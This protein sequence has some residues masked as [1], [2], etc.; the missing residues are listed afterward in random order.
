VLTLRALVRL[1]RL[2]SSLLCALP[3]FV[4]FMGRTKSFTLSLGNAMPLLFIGM[5][6]FIAND[7]EDLEKDRLIHPERPLPAR[8]L[9][10]EF[11]AILYFISLG[12]ALFSTRY[13]VAQD[14]AFWYYGLAVLS[15]SYVY[16]VDGLPSLKTVYV[17]VASSIPVLIIARWFPEEPRLYVIAVAVFLFT[18]GREIC[19]DIQD[20]AG[21]A[22]CYIHRFKPSSLAVVAFSLSAVGIVLLAFEV[23]RPGEIADLVAMTLILAMAA[24]YWFK[25]GQHRRATLLMKVQLFVG[26][27][28]LV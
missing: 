2:S 7:L 12:V 23:R 18:L 22:P 21:D 14:I 1:T 13:F 25:F 15:I 10:P 3:V 17:A 28:L 16:V 20:R 8:N 5:C 19:G 4:A 9:T 11:A 26:L 27:Y 6:T 24:L